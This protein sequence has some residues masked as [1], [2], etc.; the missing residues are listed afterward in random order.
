[1]R[2][3]LVRSEI[4]AGLEGATLDRVTALANVERLASGAH[5]FALGE[6]AERV[7]VVLSGRVDLCLPLSVRGQVAEVTVESKGPGGAFGWSAFVKP[8]RFRLSARAAEPSEVAAFPRI[9]LERLFADDAA[10]GYVVLTRIAEVVSRRL[11]T[12]Q[13]LWA[14]EFQRGIAAGLPFP[15]SAVPVAS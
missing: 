15:T 8:Y 10:S 9:A 12:M 14:R 3:V 11:L 5:P 7:Y 1:M 2:D 13:A 4:F 6:E